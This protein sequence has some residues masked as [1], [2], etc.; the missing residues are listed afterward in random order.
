MAKSDYRGGCQCGRVRYRARGEPIVA[1]ICHCTTCRRAHSAPAVAW[2]MFEQERVEFEGGES[3]EYCGT[4]D[5]AR[6]F[7]PVC[8]SQV[9]FTADYLPG[10]IDIAV[11]SLDAPESVQPAFHFWHSEHLAWAEF[12][13]D[14]PR[15]PEFPPQDGDDG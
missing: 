6:R 3:I 1:A 4:P 9:S 8:G 12:A 15:F 14:L 13:D 10:L 7:C 2:A 11:A 5:A